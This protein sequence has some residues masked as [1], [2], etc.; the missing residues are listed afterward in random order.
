MQVLCDACEERPWELLQ[1]L[2]LGASRAVRA[3]PEILFLSPP[4]GSPPCLQLCL[5]PQAGAG[6]SCPCRCLGRRWEGF[7]GW[8]AALHECSQ[9]LEEEQGG[10]GLHPGLQVTTGFGHS[11]ELFVTWVGAATPSL[12]Q[13]LDGLHEGCRCS[14]PPP[15]EEHFSGSLPVL[16][17]PT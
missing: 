9:V 13:R 4:P 5:L 8:H 10:P 12:C 16:M 11:L 7:G 6:Q 17:I 14:L 1:A 2:L 15:T 3:P